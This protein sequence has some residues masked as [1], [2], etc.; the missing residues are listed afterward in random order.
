MLIAK[1]KHFHTSS[2]RCYLEGRLDEGERVRNRDTS[3][4]GARKVKENTEGGLV[5]SMWME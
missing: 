2:Y 4:V 5:L 3:G 1:K